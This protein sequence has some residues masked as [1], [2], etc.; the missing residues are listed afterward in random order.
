MAVKCGLAWEK[1]RLLNKIKIRNKYYK[2]DFQLLRLKLRFHS[3][4]ALL[5]LKKDW[6]LIKQSRVGIEDSPFTLAMKYL[7]NS[8]LITVFEIKNVLAFLIV[9]ISQ[10]ILDEI[11]SK[12]RLEFKC[13]DY[14]NRKIFKYYGNDKEWTL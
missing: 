14:K 13:R 7:K 3:C 6:P 12:P 9:I 1:H 8:Y 10:D 11:L 4:S 5:L 2:K